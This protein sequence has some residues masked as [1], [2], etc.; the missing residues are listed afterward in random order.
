[1]LTRKATSTYTVNGTSVP[2]RPATDATLNIA[3]ANGTCTGITTAATS[4][5]TTAGVATAGAYCPDL[6]GT[7]FEGESVGVTGTISAIHIKNDSTSST[8][9]TLNVSTYLANFA[10]PAAGIFQIGGFSLEDDLTLSPSA[11]GD[12]SCLITVTIAAS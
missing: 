7:D 5:G 8:L 2:I 11:T 12:Q 4:T 1:V 9:A 6:D 3:I 10:I